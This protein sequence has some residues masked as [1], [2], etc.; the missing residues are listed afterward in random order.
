MSEG[1]LLGR[2]ISGF[3]RPEPKSEGERYA[4][5]YFVF[6]ALSLAEQAT[7]IINADRVI[8]KKGRCG[9]IIMQM[10]RVM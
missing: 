3:L 4:L 2:L 1:K 6:L 10:V 5:L 8:R 7:N 9:M